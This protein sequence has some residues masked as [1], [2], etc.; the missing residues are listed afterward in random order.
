[1]VRRVDSKTFVHKNCIPLEPY[2]KWLRARAQSLMMPY[3]TIIPIVVE[4]IVEGDIPF[5]ILHPDVPTD[6][7]E[8]QRSW[9]QLKRE[10]DTFEARFYASEKKLL[11]LTKK[12]YEEQSLNSYL[13]T[14]RKRSWVT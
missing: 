9:I 1:M 12:L 14:K 5:T 11:E 13:D 7:E 8:L 4:P 2:L 3:P 10:R 6:L